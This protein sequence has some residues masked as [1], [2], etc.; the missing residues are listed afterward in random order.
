MTTNKKEIKILLLTVLFSALLMSRFAWLTD[1]PAGFHI[2][3]AGAGYDALSL[4]R[5]GV[6][7]YLKS[8][9]LYLT[10]YGSGQSSLYA[11]LCAGLFRLFGYSKFLLRLPAALGSVLVW[12][13]GVRLSDRLFGKDSFYTVFTAFLIVICPYFVMSSRFAYD[14]NLMLGLSVVFLDALTDA[15]QSEKQV[16]LKYFAAG[17]AG[18]ILLY[19]YALSYIIL[20]LFLL[21]SLIY[22][23]R[24]RAFSL[25][26]WICMAVPLFLLALPLLLIQVINLTDL[27]EMKIGIFTLTKLDR[28]R[29]AEIGRPTVEKILRMKDA[30]LVG[31]DLT[32]DSL[33]GFPNLLK[34]SLILLPLGF[35]RGLVR[36]MENLKRGGGRPDKASRRP[37]NLDNTGMQEIS[38]KPSPELLRPLITL[39]FLAVVSFEYC[40]NAL[41]YTLNPAFFAAA[42]LITEAVEGLP[43]IAGPVMQKYFPKAWEDEGRRSKIRKRVLLGTLG[44]ISCLYLAYGIRF[45]AFYFGTF[46]ESGELQE[47]FVSDMSPAFRFIER[48]GV[49]AETVYC[50]D[51]PIG[52]LLTTEVSPYEIEDPSDFAYH[53]TASFRNITFASV[54]GVDNTAC[55]V[56]KPGLFP[57]LCDELLAS[58]FVRQS[59][60]ECDL[61][62]YPSLT[63]GN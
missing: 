8:W 19:S 25:K 36:L 14:C 39:W 26:G 13:A 17:V 22:L 56:F 32:F 40:I 23:L 43:L 3:E 42:F 31:D 53:T 10:N 50:S 27:P 61:Y 4:A 15:L 24:I 52:Y 20:P 11:F 6:D 5:Y 54:G 16:C 44:C 7:R 2:D 62:Y 46:R 29:G 38:K 59:F 63:G 28:Y 47:Y 34:P 57:E 51:P 45:A 21:L 18:G 55:Y 30:L 12:A 49:P 60:P 48:A 9:P 35:F 37:G 1:F 58:G 33:P 41:T